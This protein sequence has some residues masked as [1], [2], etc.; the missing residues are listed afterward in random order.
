[1]TLPVERDAFFDNVKFLAIVLVVCGHAWGP[2]ADDPD[3]F[4][5]LS[6]AYTLVYLFH[7]PL[8]IAVCG[9]FTRSYA[10]DPAGPKRLRRLLLTTLV[11]YLI[12]GSLYTLFRNLTRGGDWTPMNLVEPYYLTW[13]LLALFLW[14]LTSPFWLLVRWPVTISVLA[15]LA[16]GAAEPRDLAVAQFLQFLPFF[17]IGLTIRPEWLD[18]LR[19]VRRRRPVALAVFAVTLAGCYLYVPVARGEWLYRRSGHDEL[20]VSLAQ[21]WLHSAVQGV[22]AIVLCLAF[23]AL[24]PTSR[25]RWTG[26]G[27][28]TQFTYLLHGFVVQGAL[29]WGAYRWDLWTHPAGQVLITLLGIGLSVVL[30]SAVVRRATGWIVE[31]PLAWLFTPAKPVTSTNAG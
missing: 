4:R 26:F 8:F 15:S 12:F 10:R 22:V 17:V 14:R 20:D 3:G 28:G 27:E 23:L 9:Y 7:M 6:S 2:L 25:R 21:W 16:V 1:M 5:V 30:A 24:V 19:A 31:P 13:F 29:A 11:P 18:R